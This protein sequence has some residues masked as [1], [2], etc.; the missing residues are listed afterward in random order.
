[1]LCVAAVDS[2]LVV[3]W[4]SKQYYHM[5]QHLTSEYIP[6][7][8]KIR[9]SKRCLHT[10]VHSSIIYNRHSS[11]IDLPVRGEEKLNSDYYFHI[12]PGENTKE[13][14]IFLEGSHHRCSLISNLVPL[15]SRVLFARIPISSTSSNASCHPLLRNFINASR[16]SIFYPVSVS[17]AA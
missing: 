5:I 13:V 10:H 1:M 2:S 6:K 8:I 16:E 7:R 11:L 3:P 4:K 17:Y 9:D 14:A 12:I 15:F